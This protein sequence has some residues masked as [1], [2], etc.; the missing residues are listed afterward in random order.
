MCSKL[1]RPGEVV[2]IESTGHVDG[3]ALTGARR[4]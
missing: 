1:T 4:R 2:S 3:A